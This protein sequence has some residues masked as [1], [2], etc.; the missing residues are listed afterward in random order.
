MEI[1][2]HLNGTWQHCAALDPEG[3]LRY[4]ADYALQHL[5]ARDLRALSVRLPVDLGVRRFS[6]W[7]EFLFDLLPQRGVMPP[8]PDWTVLQRGAAN[9]VG[10]LRIRPPEAR[11]RRSHRGFAWAEMMA[12]G[13]GFLE[14]A[15]AAGASVSGAADAQ[16]AAPKF[17][18]VETDEGRWLPD[19]GRLG[20]IARRHALIKWP[21]PESGAQAAELLR[22]EAAYQRVAGRLGLSV[23]AE[24]PQ[25]IDGALLVPRFDRRRS[26]E[27]EI[28]LGV[29]SLGSVAGIHEP[30]GF[31]W[32]HHTALLALRGCLSDFAGGLREYLR[33]DIL[34]LALGNRAN[35]GRNTAV[36]KEPG[37]QVSL[38]PVF[39][40]GPSFLDARGLVRTLC[41]QG[42]E[43]GPMD[44]TR[45][46]EHLSARFEAANLPLGDLGSIAVFLQAFGQEIA[47][48]PEIMLECGV[49]AALVDLRRSP[50]AHLCRAL[51]AVRSP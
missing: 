29:E 10:N 45:V 8:L 50:I 6:R 37:G 7:P 11:P 13:S 40:L 38:A 39:D 3:T 43:A 22:H 14:F 26:V 48:L 1:D 18:V 42:E 15:E 32:S 31:T 51:G 46:L 9:P 2:S 41:W 21:L 28:R 24:L 44:W 34:N 27:G 33:R 49:A 30:P 12:R 5:L 35:H 19:D 47:R 36:L 23:T 17:W 4:Q 16:G 20:R 25:F